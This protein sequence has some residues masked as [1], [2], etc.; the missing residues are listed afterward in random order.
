MSIILAE[1]VA[2]AKSKLSKGF[3]GDSLNLDGKVVSVDGA[4]KGFKAAGNVKPPYAAVL[5][6]SN[7]K[8]FAN[9]AV[10]AFNDYVKNIS[11][12]IDASQQMLNSYFDDMNAVV[13]KCEIPD[14]TLSIGVVT[15]CE[16]CVVAAKT[17]NTHLL[18]YSDGE[19]FE[20]AISEYEGGKGYQLIDSVLD[21]DI[22]ALISDEA[23][24]N[25][26]YDGILNIFSSGKDLKSTVN[27][28]FTLLPVADGKDCSVVLIKLKVRTAAPVAAVAPAAPVVSVDD[29]DVPA[30][31]NNA[32]ADDSE[33]EDFE[34]QDRNKLGNKKI[35]GFIPIIALVAILAVAVGLYVASHFDFD[36]NDEDNTNAGDTPVFEDFSDDETT[37]ENS[38]ETDS[39]T[40]AETTTTEEETTT[41]PDETT[42]QRQ[43]ETATQAPETTT[44]PPVTTTKPPITTTEPPVTT[45]EP[46]VTTTE[47][48]VTTTEPPVTTTERPTQTPPDW[49]DIDAPYYG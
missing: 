17:G 10:T 7:R 34:T 19:L 37:T 11:E 27:D 18:R 49:W 26:D 23:A 6:S 44:A 41:V 30:D 15:V 32:A 43:E 45:T 36:G 12:N 38:S 31:E 39:T 8:G 33:L 20:I 28:L 24:E 16:N 35:I 5:S 48:P 25:L 29:N 13:D 22:F 2:V 9:G 3:N 40:E 4:D 14:S 47:P 42:T 21:G 46:P 1:S